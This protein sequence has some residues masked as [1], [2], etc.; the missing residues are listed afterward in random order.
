MRFEAWP[1][2]R[3]AAA[4][5]GGGALA[6]LAG[7][8][9][10]QYVGGLAPCEMCWWQRHALV[11]VLALAALALAGSQRIL[12]WLGIAALAVNAGIALFHAGVEQRWCLPELC[13][14][15]WRRSLMT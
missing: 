12:A 6:L 9:G 4:L 14:Y 13:R 10:F 3:Q 15:C 5:A 2:E 7:A 11:A 8:Y 1:A